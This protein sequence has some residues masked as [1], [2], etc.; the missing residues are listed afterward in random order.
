MILPTKLPACYQ[1]KCFEQRNTLQWTWLVPLSF[2][3]QVTLE[4]FACLKVMSG[5]TAQ[6]RLSFLHL[7]VLSAIRS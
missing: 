3:T 4:V 7:T 6:R 5:C 1:S 2:W